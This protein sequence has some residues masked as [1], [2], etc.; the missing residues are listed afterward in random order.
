MKLVNSV[1]SCE[2]IHCIFSYTYKMS[3]TYRIDKI[4]VAINNLLRSSYNET[5][6]YNLEG[7]KKDREFLEL[8]RLLII[9][10]DKNK[11]CKGVQNDVEGI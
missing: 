7:I 11:F 3:E 9:N 6:K 2:I 1:A 8:I 5:K 10:G 4:I